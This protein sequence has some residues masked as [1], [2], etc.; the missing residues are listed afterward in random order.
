[1]KNNVM[2]NAFVSLSKMFEAF[3]SPKDINDN[4]YQETQLCG[5]FVFLQ[6]KSSRLKI[7]H[8]NAITQS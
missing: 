6:V 1:M 7:I 3:F 5:I 2:G 4:N 8:Q